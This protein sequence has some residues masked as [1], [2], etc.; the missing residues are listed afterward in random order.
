MYVITDKC[1]SCGICAN[2]CPVECI[3]KGNSIYE[4]NQ[5][6]CISCGTCQSSCPNDA[7]EEQTAGCTDCGACQ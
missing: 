4:I 2:E 3:S 6:E 5:D 7:I 1:I